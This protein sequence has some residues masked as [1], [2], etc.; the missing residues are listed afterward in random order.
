MIR[1]IV[2]F[3]ADADGDWVAELSCWHNQHV[4]HRPPFQERAWV[5][6]PVGRDA[7]LQSSIECP[8]CDR[9]ELPEG[10]TVL[11][12]AGPWDEH[13]LPEALRRSHR[14]PKQRWG[15]LQVHSGAVDF[16]FLPDNAPGGPLLHLLE[17]SHQ[18]IPPHLSHRVLLI[19]PTRVELEFLGRRNEQGPGLAR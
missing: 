10:L 4:R 12:R 2:G 6:D 5:V 14:T 1:S 15:R 7:H 13:S 8:L 18:A 9:A 19:G 11:E 3:H 17:G 16:Q